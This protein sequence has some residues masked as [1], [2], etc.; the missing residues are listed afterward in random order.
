MNIFK[1][2]IANYVKDDEAI[3]AAALQGKKQ[4]Q[5][6]ELMRKQKILERIVVKTW[7]E[8]HQAAIGYRRPQ[9]GGTHEGLR[10]HHD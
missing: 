6:I 10:R 5:Y 4:E 7:R 2:L 9:A 3:M 8:A 1:Q